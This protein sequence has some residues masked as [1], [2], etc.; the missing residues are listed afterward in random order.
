M[1]GIGA[2]ADRRQGS[3]RPAPRTRS[4]SCASW[5]SASMRAAAV[6]TSSTLAFEAFAAVPAVEARS[7]SR[8]RLHLRAPA[9]LP[10]RPGLLGEPGR[11]G[12]RRAAGRDRRLCPRGSP[13]CTPSRRCRKPPRSPPPTSASS[14]SCARAAAR[15]RAAV[16]RARLAD[17]AEHDLYLAF[18]T[19]DAAGRRPTAATATSPARCARSRPPSRPSTASS[20]T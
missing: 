15:R 12:A 17:G 2:G 20:T 16:D 19:P 8:A 14:T 3:V 13:P 18:Q 4:A 11:G 1:F 7:R 9:R 10:A 5:S 6:A